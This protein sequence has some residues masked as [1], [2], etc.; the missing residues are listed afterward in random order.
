MFN[1]TALGK[2]R[3]FMKRINIIG[4]SGSGKSTI[5][6][7]LAAKLGYPYFQMDA[8]FW[9]PNWTESN[10]EEFFKAVAEVAAKPTWVLDGNYTRTQRIK[11][12]NVDTVIWID[13]SFSRTLYQA[14]KRAVTRIIESEELW[15]GTGNKETFKKTFMSRD[16]ILIW[17]IK[18]YKKNR[19]R[20]QAMMHSREFQHIKFVRLQS[21]KAAEAFIS[22]LD[23][24]A[25]EDCVPAS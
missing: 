18:S 8:L 2:I 19:V 23:K 15:K 1:G 13:Y 3:E 5:G 16:S 14:L 25:S 21:P 12:E 20:Y 22:K 9:K 4:T 6:K 11:W 10:D 24:N 7:R 17:T